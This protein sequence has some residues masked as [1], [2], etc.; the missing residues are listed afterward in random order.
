MILDVEISCL[1]V[2]EESAQV[3][4]LWALSSEQ[5]GLLRN[6]AAGRS[7]FCVGPYVAAFDE[8]W[9]WPTTGP[10]DQCPGPSLATC[11]IKPVLTLHE[12]LID[13]DFGSFH[14]VLLW[15]RRKSWH[16]Q[17]QTVQYTIH[18][19]EGTQLYGCRSLIFK[20]GMV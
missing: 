15:A 2:G 9:R 16:V 7:R 1:L 3:Y 6:R 8:S 12:V 17:T 20:L 4:R 19:F 11:R 18:H 5:S 10:P 13:A 14:G